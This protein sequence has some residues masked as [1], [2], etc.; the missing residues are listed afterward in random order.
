[1]AKVE[2]SI[3]LLR[4]LKEN[5]SYSEKLIVEEFPYLFVECEGQKKV[6]YF[7]K[8]EEA[9]KDLMNKRNEDF[10]KKSIQVDER[11]LDTDKVF[12]QEV[13]SK[14]DFLKSIEQE[15][16]MMFISS[17]INGIMSSGLATPVRQH[18]FDN[19]AEDAIRL[20]D[21]VINKLKS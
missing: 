6:D 20:A 11:L 8:Y 15:N 12:V 9:I 13:L 3:E 19:I 21:A 18:Q 4:K 1:M 16:R 17:A 2:I 5:N 7:D 10:I 14:E